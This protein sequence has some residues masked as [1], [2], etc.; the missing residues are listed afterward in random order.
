MVQRGYHPVPEHT[1]GSWRHHSYPMGRILSNPS[2]NIPNQLE[3]LNFKFRLCMYLLDKISS[4]SFAAIGPLSKLMDERMVL[5][6]A[7][8]VPML[9]GS[10]V[11][12]L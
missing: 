2:H 3:G 12:I 6:L 10:L 8:M 9:V 5:I 1:H 7:G 4:D 11:Y